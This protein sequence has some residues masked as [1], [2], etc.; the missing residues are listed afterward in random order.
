MTAQEV[1]KEGCMRGL[2]WL[3]EIA[4]TEVIANELANAG[5]IMAAH[6]EEDLAAGAGGAH[7][8]LRPAAW[9]QLR[10]IPASH[11]PDESRD[12]WVL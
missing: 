9:P 10:G 7:S 8:K 5:S 11:Y 2:V 1:E 3:I 12:S 6:V 4:L